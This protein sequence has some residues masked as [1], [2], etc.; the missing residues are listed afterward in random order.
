MP[1]RRRAGCLRNLLEPGRHDEP[2]SLSHVSPL[3]RREFAASLD[4]RLY[5]QPFVVTCPNINCKLRWYYL[6]GRRLSETP[7]GDSRARCVFAE[8]FI[9]DYFGAFRQNGAG[10]Q[11]NL[12]ALG[13]D[14]GNDIAGYP[15][16]RA[17]PVAIE[18]FDFLRKGISRIGHRRAYG[19]PF[20][21]ARAAAQG[22][23]RGAARCRT[24]RKGVEAVVACHA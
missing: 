3:H 8:C 18:V 13:S 5:L 10:S 1:Y 22:V 23:D 20:D 4:G 7:F 6:Q 2:I 9:R 17:E 11:R 14:D 12:P 16:D 21:V 19:L 24:E 15:S